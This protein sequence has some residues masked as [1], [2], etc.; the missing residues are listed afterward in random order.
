MQADNLLPFHEHHLSNERKRRYEA[1]TIK[2]GMDDRP[3]I[4]KQRLHRGILRST[5]DLRYTSPQ[6]VEQNERAIRESK[7]FK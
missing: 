5:G 7:F 1:M 6:T 4:R 3:V 2:M